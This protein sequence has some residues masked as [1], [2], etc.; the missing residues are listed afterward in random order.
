M[1]DFERAAAGVAGN[2]FDTAASGVIDDQRSGLRNTLYDALLSNPE[3]AARATRLG[4][5]TG[6][7]PDLVERNLPEVER[8]ARLDQLDALPKENPVLAA[9]LADPVNAK[10]SHDDLDTLGQL[11]KASLFRPPAVPQLREGYGFEQA[12]R[13]LRASQNR[14]AS[15]VSQYVE[16]NMPASEVM[17]R[18]RTVLKGFTEPVQRGVARARRGITLLM[19]MAGLYEGD[20][21]GLAVRLA[22][23]NRKVE[24]YPVPENVQAGM[25]AI[26]GAEGFGD[27]AWQ[28]LTHPGAVKETVLESLGASSP[29]LLG[30]GAMS[31]LGPGGTAAGAGLGSFVVEYSSTLQDVMDENGVNASDPMAMH[32]ALN[33][34]DLMDAAREKAL[35]RGVPVAAFDAI[36]A[37]FAGK[38]LLGAK[39]T[40][41]S[42]GARAAGELALQ[43]GGGAAGEAT[44][45]YATDEFKPGD[46]LLEAIAELPT[47]IVEIPANYRQAI[48]KATRA[49]QQT[50][51]L[52]ELN[53]LAKASKVAQRDPES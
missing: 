45:Q 28:I 29:S 43:A 42:A 47:G 6:L 5:Q 51:A 27:A 8:S 7:A 3:V 22:N 16:R 24:S 44:A 31:V 25:Q 48:G 12:S 15:A 1:D 17:G 14:S 18:E 32:A 49:E 26:S 10:L 36:T 21:A 46:I 20:E 2:E 40:A 33:N 37:G 30:A 35:A 4:R 38:L 39:N 41:G 19:G 52:D 11:G 34:P 23:Q 9:W 13:D 53:N 50:Q